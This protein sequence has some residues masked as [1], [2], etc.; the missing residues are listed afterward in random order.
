[1]DT[2]L[3][4]PPPAHY[5]VAILDFHK[6]LTINMTHLW[7]TVEI[8]ITMRHSQPIP[9]PPWWIILILIIVSSVSCFFLSLASQQ[10]FIFY[11]LRSTPSLAW[12]RWRCII[13]IT[14][15]R[16]LR[17]KFSSVTWCACS[18][19]CRRGVLIWYRITDCWFC[20]L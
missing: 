5:P 11:W 20:N 9:F 12:A 8:W 6:F 7:I 2:L 15:S 1:M 14:R 18:R 13:I 4:R 16:G 19:A 3:T 10:I 17:C